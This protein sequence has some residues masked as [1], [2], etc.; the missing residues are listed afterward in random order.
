MQPEPMHIRGLHGSLQGKPLLVAR[1]ATANPLQTPGV[2]GQV[3]LKE[4]DGP[5]AQIVELRMNEQ[6]LWQQLVHL[7]W[8]QQPFVAL[9]TACIAS[10]L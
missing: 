10:E 3:T 1:I 6:S 7:A 5:R 8:K 9:P 2:C 4:R